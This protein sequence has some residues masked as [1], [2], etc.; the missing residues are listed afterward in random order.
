MTTRETVGEVFCDA[1]A[2]GQVAIQRFGAES[3][4]RMVNEE[5]GE[6][7]TAIARRGRGRSTPQ[8]I[9]GECADVIMV[10]IQCGMLHADSVEDFLRVVQEKTAELSS[11][12]QGGQ[13]ESGRK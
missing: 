13:A 4:I 12:T 10:A 3:Q 1:I 8:D 5:C 2:V 6:L 9:A 11:K 7:V